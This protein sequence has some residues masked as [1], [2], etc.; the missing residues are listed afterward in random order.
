MHILHAAILQNL[1]MRGHG[2]RSSKNHKGK[3]M[4]AE[5]TA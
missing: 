5:M 2:S 3:S 1:C 4:L